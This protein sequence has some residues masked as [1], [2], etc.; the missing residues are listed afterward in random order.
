MYLS[1]LGFCFCLSLGPESFDDV[2]DNCLLK[3]RLICWY[4]VV[5]AD[6]ADLAD[7]VVVRTKYFRLFSK[8]CKMI[9]AQ[10]NIPALANS[11][12]PIGLKVKNFVYPAMFFFHSQLCFLLFHQIFF[13]CLTNF[14]NF[15]KASYF[16]NLIITIKIH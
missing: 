1:I 2:E 10:M 12:V 5:W 16:Q 9:E 15:L 3:L 6:F 8:V 14:G 13:I 4:C 11:A 7:V